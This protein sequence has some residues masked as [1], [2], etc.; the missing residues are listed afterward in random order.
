[1]NTS[2]YPE[3]EII[4][5]KE[6]KYIPVGID[7]TRYRPI[8]KEF[9][10]LMRIS[11]KSP[12]DLLFVLKNYT[13]L[14]EIVEDRLI[15]KVTKYFCYMNK[16]K[17]LI[18]LI[19]YV[20]RV[21]A[22]CYI[23]RYKF[24]KY[25]YHNEI[26]NQMGEDFEHLRKTIE[27]EVKLNPINM[28][29]LIFML[30]E[31]YLTNKYSNK[32]SKIQ[33]QFK[34]ESLTLQKLEKNLE[35]V[36]RSLREDAWRAYYDKINVMSPEFNKIFDKLLKL[37]IKMSKTLGFEN[38]RDFYHMQK[39]RFDYTPDDIFRFHRAVEKVVVPFVKEINNN[40]KESLNIESMRPWDEKADSFDEELKPYEND[41]E[42]VEK[43]ITIFNKIDPE[44]GINLQLMKNSGFLDLTNRKG[45]IPGAMSMPLANHGASFII[46]NSVGNQRNVETLAHE[47][48]HAMHNFCMKNLEISMYKNYTMEAAELA[49]MSMEFFILDHLDQ[50][51]NSK[52][53]IKHAIR[54]ALEYLVRFIPWF[55]IVD[56]FQQ[57][58]YLNS[59]HSIEERMN[60]FGSL[61][62]RFNVST[63]IDWSGIEA[64]K[65]LKWLRQTHIFQSPFYYIEYAIAQIGAIA[66]YRNYKRNPQ[67]T[68]LQ[69]KN[70]LSL[71]NSK[72]LREL[73]SAAGI[74]FDFSEEY[75][76]ELMDFLKKEL[77]SL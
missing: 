12:E 44:F 36:D 63:G 7:G 58:T 50:F 38:A 53:E 32:Y 21:V 46:Q 10:R 77:N 22:R 67:K 68:I 71:G 2:L 62:D 14:Y 43:M 64:Y 24:H 54:N 26:F 42:L 3:L 9:K 29:F 45:K 18:Q 23:K 59:N 61:I 4:S 15:L 5:P 19:W 11:I 31:L 56:S 25:I 60:Y 16:K 48:G 70:F 55:M 76:S 49:S 69:Y 65:N 39:R 35:S 66:M 73:Y 52:A 41:E 6:K 34:G 51:Y 20:L 17:P 40:L 72:P 28:K 13:E 47:G 74:K 37:R 75:L 8:K 27:N 1:M 33:V 57:W 30:K